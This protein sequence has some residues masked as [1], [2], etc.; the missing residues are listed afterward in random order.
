[1]YNT[2]FQS[3]WKI[4][5]TFSL[6]FYCRTDQFWTIQQ[7]IWELFYEKPSMFKLVIKYFFYSY[8][9][10]YKES[11]EIDRNRYSD[12][13]GFRINYSKMGC[14]VAIYSHRNE[15]RQ[16]YGMHNRFINFFFR[17]LVR[18]FKLWVLDFN[19]CQRITI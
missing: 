13:I 16:F 2:S 11:N 9:E 8:A 5:L 12:I 3:C 19:F 15:T 10:L 17:A 6:R 4:L 7:K 18:S 1:M 14:S